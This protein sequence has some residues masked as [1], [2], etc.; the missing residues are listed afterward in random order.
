MSLLKDHCW[1]IP[2]IEDKVKTDKIVPYKNKITIWYQRDRYGSLPEELVTYTPKDDYR[3]TQDELCRYIHDYYNQELTED[4]LSLI[5]KTD[6]CWGY[7]E[8]AKDALE[9]HKY[10]PRYEIMGDCLF[11]EGVEYVSRDN[12]K[13]WLGS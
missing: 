10:I 2:C 13:I 11:F 1:F 6:D 7:C 3:F 9:N 5:S 4:E 8:K 12:Y